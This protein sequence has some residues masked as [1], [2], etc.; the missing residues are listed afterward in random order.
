MFSGIITHQ[1]LWFSSATTSITLQ[2]MQ[3]MAFFWSYDTSYICIRTLILATIIE[4]GCIQLCVLEFVNFPRIVGVVRKGSKICTSVWPKYRF[5][6]WTF[7]GWVQ[8][9]SKFSFDI[10]GGWLNL[11]LNV[12]EVWLVMFE[13]WS[14]FFLEFVETGKPW[15]KSKENWEKHHL[16]MLYFNWQPF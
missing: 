2:K 8:V 1:S 3:K 10:F 13:L 14:D 6:V 9:N 5:K 7:L 11:S 16:S 15:Q 12:F 4:C